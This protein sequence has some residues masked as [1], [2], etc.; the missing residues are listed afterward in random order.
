MRLLDA[1]CESY[2]GEPSV[3][4]W[5][6]DVYNVY[7]FFDKSAVRLDIERKDGKDGIQWQE[8][9]QIKNECGFANFD[10][11]ELYPAE[12]DVINTGNWRHLYVLFGGVGLVR[13]N[14]EGNNNGD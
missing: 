3:G 7:A 11:V 10:A 14:S 6:S 12:K 5:E 4:V 2:F 9:Q 13:R 8:L 1:Q